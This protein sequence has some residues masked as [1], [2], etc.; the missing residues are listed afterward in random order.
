[1]P[2]PDVLKTMS[3]GDLI[4]YRTNIGIALD[5]IQMVHGGIFPTNDKTV[6]KLMR[7]REEIR[8][9]LERRES[10]FALSGTV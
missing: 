4:V 2:K 1:M 9:E 8:G 7:R 10:A 5:V 6:A 3:F